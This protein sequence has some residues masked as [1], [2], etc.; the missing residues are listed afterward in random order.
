M[1]DLLHTWRRA[2]TAQ[3]KLPTS[4]SPAYASLD[5]VLQHALRAAR[6]MLSW[7]CEK[8]E[9]PDPGIDEPPEAS[10]LDAEAERYVE[11]LLA[12]WRVPLQSVD[13]KRFEAVH[14][15]RGG[16]ETSL[17]ARLEHAVVHPQRHR[18]QLQELLEGR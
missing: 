7:I 2:R 5:T 1:R 18:F 14:K 16:H 6:N 13:A 4:D 17:L 8:L 11:H 10:R 15:D 12:R 3:V 9:L